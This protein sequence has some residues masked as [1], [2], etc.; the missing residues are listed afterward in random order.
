MFTGSKKSSYRDKVPRKPPLFNKEEKYYL[1]L[2]FAF[3][4]FLATGG[5][6]K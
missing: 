4:G 5:K 6:L 2:K 3:S 1:Y